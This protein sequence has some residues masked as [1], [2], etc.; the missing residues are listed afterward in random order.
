MIAWSLR[1]AECGQCA[2]GSGP[3]PIFASPWICAV[4][5]VDLD[6]VMV[7]D[8]DSVTIDLDSLN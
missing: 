7:L 5:L 2:T 1:C 6:P 4:C 3:A 8:L